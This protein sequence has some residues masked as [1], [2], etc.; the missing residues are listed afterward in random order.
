ME[1]AELEQAERAVG[2]ALARKRLDHLNVLGFGEIT[3]VIGWPT[4]APRYA[5]KRLPPLADRTRL[6]RYA[7]NIGR[8][9]HL[10]AERGIDTPPSSTHLVPAR[11]GGS[12]LYVAQNLYPSESLAS[13]ILRRTAPSSDHPVVRAVVD[14]A[15]RAD[16]A[17]G[18]DAQF[19]NWVHTE[20]HTLLIDTS[21][22]MIRSNGEFVLDVDLMLTPFPAVARPAMRQFVV[23]DILAR[24]HDPRSILIDMA[25]NLHREQ[26]AG[27][28]DP[29]VDYANRHLAAP[30]TRAE[31]DDFYRSDARLWSTIQRAKRLNR[32]WTTTVRRHTYPIALPGPI[33][34]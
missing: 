33:Q 1:A 11:H 21:T 4:H 18:I 3:V 26:L 7:V 28:I 30:I 5:L 25:A 9:H 20:H 10:L 13:N 23:P 32:W 14:R 31:V 29:V 17:V 8:Y 24:F 12:V 16:E 34:R 6:E 2:D 15:L 19:T 22:P 27:W